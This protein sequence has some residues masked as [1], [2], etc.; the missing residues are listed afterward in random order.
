MTVQEYKAR[1]RSL[2][3]ERLGNELHSDDL[4]RSI[5]QNAMFCMHQYRSYC[6]LIKENPTRAYAVAALQ[7]QARAYTMGHALRSAVKDRVARESRSI[8]EKQRFNA[9]WGKHATK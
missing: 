2:A 5:V 3:V 6:T 9:A 4:V 7:W 1:M 8:Q